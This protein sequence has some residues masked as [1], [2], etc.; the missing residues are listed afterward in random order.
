MKLSKN[1]SAVLLGDSI[2][3]GFLRY[4]NIWYKLFDENTL[5]CGI[6]GYKIQ[7]VLRRAENIL[8]SRSLEFILINCG[9]KSLDTDD[10]EKMA[11]GLFCIALALK[12]RMN[13]KIVINGIL[14]RDEK[15]TARR[16][17]LFIVNELLGVY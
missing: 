5:N 16:Q 14:P 9:T 15:N 2:V 12:K 6:G 17:K 13:L 11:D 1:V 4:H 10:F 7:K 3:A 8:L